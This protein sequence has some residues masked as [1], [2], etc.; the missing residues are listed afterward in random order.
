MNPHKFPIG[1][2]IELPVTGT[3]PEAVY[4]FE[5]DSAA[6]I[7]AAIAAQRPLL[8]RGEPGTGKSQLARAAA[9]EL[10]RLFVSEVVQARSESQD[11]Q[12]HFD[13]VARLAE[14]QAAGAAK[15][16]EKDVKERL[17]PRRFLSPGP[18][19][20]VFDWYS[21]QRQYR[22]CSHN[23]RKPEPP[24]DWEPNQGAVLLI[25]EIDKADSDLPNGLLETLGNGAFTVPWLDRPVG[26]AEETEPPL[27]MI[28]T[29]EERELPGAF[30]RRCLVLHL[31]L[32]VDE[33]A[34]KRALSERG[35]AHFQDHCSEA[36]RLEA[37]EQLW[38]DR[39]EAQRQGVTPPGQAEYLDLLR[40]LCAMKQSESEQ[41]ALLGQISEF[42]LKK[43]G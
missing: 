3:W 19:W 1:E 16:P 13:A 14:A 12:Y 22:I 38:R 39:Q 5:K 30:V 11:L 17:D 9:Y 43:F 6:A 40:A 21:A 37:A 24:E 33:E 4:V 23:I 26:L 34:F 31:A 25:D 27:V 41:L 18:L 20:W 15:D 2:P 42:V 8:I 10:G 7:N 36:V 35:R 29:N 28:T 32:P